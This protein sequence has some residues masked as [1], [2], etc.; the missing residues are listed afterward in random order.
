MPRGARRL[1]EECV[2]QLEAADLILHAGDFVSA[3]FYRELKRLGPLEAVHGNM[4]DDRLKRTLPASRVVEVGEARVGMVHEP[5]RIAGFDDCDAI[6]FGHTHMPHAS[7]EGGRWLLNP[8]QSDRA[9][10]CL[11]ALDAAPARRTSEP[12]TRAAKPGL[13]P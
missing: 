2:R 1:P 3:E 12:G 10:A 8:W 9:Q 6:V 7:R 11:G 13:A 4:D 5:A